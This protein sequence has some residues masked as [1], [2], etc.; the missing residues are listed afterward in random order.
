MITTNYNPDVLSCLANLS[1]DEVFTP[2]SLANEMLD[3]LPK[4]I[5]N[6]KD[7]KFL[8]PFTKSGIF[9][10]EIAKRLLIGLEHKI[11]D[12]QSRIDHILKNQV[13]GIAI[14]ELTSL[15]SRRSV[16]CSKTA[17]GLYSICPS[18]EN[19]AGN[20]IHD[21]IKHTW[22]KGKCRFCGAGKDVYDRDNTLETY[23]Y[24]F[25]HTDKPEKIFNMKF[26]VIIGN[27]PY[28][29][30]DGGFGASAK[31]IYHKFVEQA[32]RLN[33][34]YLSMII[35]ARWF[36]GGRVGELSDFRAEMLKDERIRVLHDFADASDCFPGVEIKGGVNYFLWD[37]DNKGKCEIYSHDGASVTKSER[38]L[39]EQGSETF[40]R[41]NEAIPILR[42]VLDKKEE[43]FSLIVS[44][45]DPFGFDIR[46]ENSMKR[47]KPKYRHTKFENSVHFYYNGW[48]KDGIGYIDKKDVK[49]NADLLFK[50]KFFV[51]KAV[52]SGDSKTDII[53]P[54][55]PKLNSCCSETYIAI[56]PFESESYMINAAGYLNT[57]FFHFLVSLKK[58]TQEARRGVYQFVPIQ[59]FSESWTDQKLYEK[60]G[61]HESEI[62]FIESMTR[63]MEASDE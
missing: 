1:N 19:D 50:Y 55:F 14:T 58:I 36:A 53:K 22:F 29:L 25:I 27:P 28:Q 24:Q 18:F 52:G 44:A 37:R 2:P 15:L 38:Y 62:A 46:E 60:Y 63:P 30:S 47:V 49:K 57:K 8:D 20:I 17:N 43:S 40:I 51:P 13:Y 45:N 34:R 32:K 61:L 41:R 39:L 35:P 21:R 4:T 5:W 48:R 26:D 7:A 54:V 31:P 12:K 56:G 23:A 9:L 16:Y 42:K 33:P 6:D 3:L 10:R 11:P 59:D